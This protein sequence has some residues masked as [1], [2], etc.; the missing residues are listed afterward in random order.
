MDAATPP[1]H[2]Y[3][4]AGFAAVDLPDL[5]PLLG[6]RDLLRAFSTLFHGGEESVMVRLLVLRS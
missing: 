4:R 3:L 2:D 6:A 1:L 5:H